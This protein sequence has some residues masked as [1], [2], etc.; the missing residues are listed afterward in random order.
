MFP[1]A[2]LEDFDF[3]TILDFT[4]QTVPLVTDPDTEKVLPYVQSSCWNN[5]I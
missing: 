5:D 1:V 2:G 4:G 3:R